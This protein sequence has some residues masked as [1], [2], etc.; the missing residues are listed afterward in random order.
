MIRKPI[1]K[2]LIFVIILW[3]SALVVG[4]MLWAFMGM[5]FAGEPAGGGIGVYELGIMVL[6]LV[7]TGILTAALLTLW[8]RA[9]YAGAFAAFVVSV[10]AVVSQ[11]YGYLM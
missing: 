1:H 4:S 3:C 8:R 2:L 6:P 9:Y 10:I 5:L 11:F 7:A